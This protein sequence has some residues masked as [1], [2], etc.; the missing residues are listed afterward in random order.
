MDK[1]L[2]TWIYPKYMKKGSYHDGEF[3]ITFPKERLVSMIIGE[4]TS[5]EPII[6]IR[7]TAM[8]S[9]KSKYWFKE[10]QIRETDLDIFA[11]NIGMI[12]KECILI[13]SYGARPVPSS[14][15]DKTFNAI[16][17]CKMIKRWYTQNYDGTIIHPKLF[18]YPIGFPAAS[19]WLHGNLSE[20]MKVMLNKRDKYE[21]K[22]VNKVF[23]DV[24]LLGRPGVGIERNVV[25]RELLGMQCEHLVILKQRTTDIPEVYELYSKHKFVVSTHGLGL[26]CHRTWEVFL[27][28]GILITKHSPMDYMY[29]GLPVIYVEN[30]SEILDR[31]N[32]DKWARE[33][34]H[35]THKD[36]IIPK[37][38]RRYWI[39]EKEY[40]FNIE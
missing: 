3:L 5:G 29:D 1:L 13:S 25:K 14:L 35:L 37:M 39:E 12:E 2:D 36:N 24:H 4:M 21:G 8:I 38:K 18:P 19:C 7:N 15:S 27:V 11:N 20:T 28:G 6:W 10:D 32:L 34:E 17:N 33:V 31:R 16:I 23:C 26:D 40:N 30:W 22:K 9:K